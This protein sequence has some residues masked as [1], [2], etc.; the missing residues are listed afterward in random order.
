MINFY[1][2]SYRV[3]RILTEKFEIIPNSDTPGPLES[4]AIERLKLWKKE[5]NEEVGK[6]IGL[7]GEKW[8]LSLASR[9]K[10]RDR[11]K[12][13]RYTQMGEIGWRSCLTHKIWKPYYNVFDKEGWEVM[14]TFVLDTMIR[15]ENALRNP[16]KWIG[17]RIKNHE[18]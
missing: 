17:Q 16:I 3:G 5:F 9:A 11:I 6:I 7:L 14:A 1:G 10:G 15:F 2:K 18:V 13:W 12:F 4:V 8:F